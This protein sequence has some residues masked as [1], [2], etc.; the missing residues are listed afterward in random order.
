MHH[1]HKADL[2][3]RKASTWTVLYI[4]A[5]EQGHKVKNTKHCTY[6]YSTRRQILRFLGVHDIRFVERGNSDSQ[7]QNV[8]CFLTWSPFCRL[9][10]LAG[11]QWRCYNPS[12]HGAIKLLSNTCI[13]SLH[14]PPENCSPLL[15][16]RLLQRLPSNS[17]CLQG[18]WPATAGCI[19]PCLSLPSTRHMS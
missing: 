12:L 14:G 11:L 17:C 5:V 18:Y 8:Y 13:T 16:E 19:V 7:E 10:R 1:E 3:T 9:L 4:T 15:Q 2:N 6:Q